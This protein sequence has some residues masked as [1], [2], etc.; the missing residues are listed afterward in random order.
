[1]E[2]LLMAFLA[3]ALADFVFRKAPSLKQ[4]E[5][6][7]IPFIARHGIIVTGLTFLLMIGYGFINALFFSLLVGLTHFLI[8][9][10]KTSLTQ[11]RGKGF[12][13]GAFLIDQALHLFVIA[14]I[15]HGFHFYLTPTFLNFIRIFGLDPWVFAELPWGSI[16]A[17]LVIYMYVAFGGAVFMRMVLEVIYQKV[18]EDQ[19]NKVLSGG[20]EEASLQ[21]VGTGRIIGILERT[22]VFALFMMNQVPAIAWIIAAKS[23][24]R[25]RNLNEKGFAEYYLI[26]TLM[27]VLIAVVGGILARMAG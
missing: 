1:M 14:W 7:D 9:M 26:G 25:F 16:L 18:P 11:K 5:T 13:L 20:I 24:A 10:L 27:S 23:L 19:K 3:H 17:N 21:V 15:A 22:L 8:D 4:K 6:L 12:E 2:G